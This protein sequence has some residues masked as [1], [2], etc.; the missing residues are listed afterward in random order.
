MAV[1]GRTATPARWEDRI[2]LLP[3][4]RL[5]QLPTPLHRAAALEQALDSP[6]LYVKRDDLTGFA[7]GGN[8]VRSLE[9]LI[10]AALDEGCDV[11]VTGGGPTSAHCLT[12]AAA[13]QVAGLACEL[14]YF[15]D[16]PERVPAAQALA[17]DAGA[18]VRFTGDP[19][20]ASVERHLEET[21]AQLRDGGHRP[22]VVPRGGATTVGGLAYAGAVAELSSQLSHLGVK[23]E[24][25]LL[26]TGSCGTQAGVLAGTI[27]S[28]APWRV[29]G[30]SVSRPVHECVARVTALASAGTERLGARP[31]HAHEIIVVDARGPGF[32]RPSQAG[33]R[34]ARLASANEGL[35]LDDVYTA[36]ALAQLPTVAGSGPVVFWHTGGVLSVVAD[37]VGRR[38][39][40]AP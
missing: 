11:L 7:F 16:P 29:V 9:L 33:M 32:G 36:K 37:A 2:G 18:R 5:A 24:L 17:R 39:E 25:V 20:R 38:D 12:A 23:P 28:G 8:K 13:A 22:F 15:G 34:T 27:A 35:V 10:G 21:A 3:R 40:G 30:A 1:N 26:A 14:V 4:A 31:P 6:P 19:E